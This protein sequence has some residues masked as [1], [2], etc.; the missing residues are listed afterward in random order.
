[1]PDLKHLLTELEKILRGYN[2]PIV[3]KLGPGLSEKIISEMFA[4]IG[5][6]NEDLIVLYNWKNGIS[7]SEEW[8]IGEFDF[9]GFGTFISLE[10]AIE[11]YEYLSDLSGQKYLLPLFTN[12]AGDYVFF[13]GDRESINFER[14]LF[15]SPP[16]NLSGEAVPVYDSLQ[17]F[18]KTT[19]ECYQKKRTHFL[20][21]SFKLTTILNMK[22]RKNLIQIRNTGS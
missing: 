12:G 22:F 9:F 11:N 1:M 16:I 17:V 20:M 15:Y 4:K 8:K 13:D 2:A 7:Y 3:K 5:M 19:I 21:G 18:L 10:D 14:L 6:R